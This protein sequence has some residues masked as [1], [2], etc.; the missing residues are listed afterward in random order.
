MNSTTVS[1]SPSENSAPRRG[2]KPTFISAERLE[3]LARTSTSQLSIAGELGL[4]Q[5]GLIKR[6]LADTD[7][8]RAY[9]RGRSVYEASRPKR[10]V[11]PK[12]RKSVV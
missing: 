1:D 6:L 8:R 9:E 2:R 5:S 3:E 4:S 7:L 12:D 10:S 11:L